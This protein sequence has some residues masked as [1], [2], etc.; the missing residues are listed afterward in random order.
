MYRSSI[1]SGVFLLLAIGIA[2]Q[3][4]AADEKPARGDS[5]KLI[6]KLIQRFGTVVQK[7]VEEKLELSD[8]QKTKLTKL[9]KD[10]D[11][12]NQKLLIRAMMKVSDLQDALDKAKNDNDA[13]DLK[14]DALDIGMLTLELVKTKR[15]IDGKFRDILTD[16]QKKTY[17]ELSRPARPRRRQ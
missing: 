15:E 16:D 7:D 8:E 17:D 4:Q 3:A 11:S 12:R 1:V 10:L 5:P 14:T 9:Q 2:G 6:E 13:G